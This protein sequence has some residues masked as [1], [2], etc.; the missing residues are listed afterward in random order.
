[1]MDKGFQ[2]R[3][4]SASRGKRLRRKS[5]QKWDFGDYFKNSFTYFAL[6]TKCSS[7]NLKIGEIEL[8]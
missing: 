5:L 2:S 6:E 3:C 4:I 7:V 1:M 8:T